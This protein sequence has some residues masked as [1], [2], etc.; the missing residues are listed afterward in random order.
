M[1]IRGFLFY[2][3]KMKR[4]LPIVGLIA[5]CVGLGYACFRVGYGEGKADAE[6]ELTAKQREQEKSR[7]MIRLRTPIDS[8][9]LPEQSKF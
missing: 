8:G 5:L 2:E 6:I 3:K 4:I 1:S 7:K 9:R